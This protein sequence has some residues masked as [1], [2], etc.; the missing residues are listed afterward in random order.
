M[1]YLTD[2]GHRSGPVDEVMTS[3]TLT[4]LYR[5]PITVARVA[6]QIVVVGTEEATHE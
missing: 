2:A 1:L 6:G 3:E 5:S 4:A